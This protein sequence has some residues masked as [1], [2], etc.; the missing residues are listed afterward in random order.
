MDQMP[1]LIALLSTGIDILSL[2]RLQWKRPLFRASLSEDRHITTRELAERFKIN[3][4]FGII[5]GNL[6]LSEQWILCILTLF[7]KE[8]TV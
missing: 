3:E 5:H 6:K 7:Q 8:A 4:V 1:H 2:A